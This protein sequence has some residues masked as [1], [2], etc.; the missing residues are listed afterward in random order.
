M[1]M[2][3][4]LVATQSAAEATREKIFM[5][6]AQLFSEKGYY[7]VSSYNK[8]LGEISYI[9]IAY[10]QFLLIFLGSIIILNKRKSS[11]TRLFLSIILFLPLSSLLLTEYYTIKSRLITIT[12]IALVFVFAYEKFYR[13]HLSFASLTFSILFALFNI[14]K[15]I[16]NQIRVRIL[17]VT[18]RR[19]II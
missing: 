17:R 5:T 15:I 13:F 11:R 12:L 18:S 2:L 9:G 3:K 14:R 7:G 19:L 10:I 4:N 6:A 16:L 1:F 8:Y